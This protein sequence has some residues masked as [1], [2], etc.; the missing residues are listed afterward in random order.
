MSDFG[1]YHDDFI[2]STSLL[3]P[4]ITAFALCGLVASFFTAWLL[5]KIFPIMS[6]GILWFLIG[7]SLES[8]IFPLE[9]MHEHRNYLPSLGLFLLVAP[10]LVTKKRNHIASNFMSFGVVVAVF[11]YFI[12][13]THL[14]ADMYGDDFRRT[15]IEAGYRVESVRS[16]YEAGAVLANLYNQHREPMLM[17]LAK[18]HF[19]RVVAL[20][21][22]DKLALIGLMQLDCLSTQLVQTEIYNELKRRLSKGKWTYIDRT[23]MHG[24]A[25]MSNE[26]KLCLTR[27]Q[28]D[29]LFVI[30]L[31]SKTLTAQDRSVVFSD[32][33]LYLW[34]GQKDYFAARNILIRAVENGSDDVL[35]RMNLLQLFRFLG[36]KRNAEILLEDLNGRDLGRQDR[37]MVKKV[38]LEMSSENV[39]GGE[40]VKN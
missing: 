2:V 8:T 11:V 18:N 34:L 31:E 4:Y 40:N 27:N 36:D 28:V 29:E 20:D 23:V 3:V 10:G 9:L 13:I 38:A 15:Q 21:P 1:L 6:F 7:H 12:L 33:S 22:A 39:V 19:E 14:R 37:N 26:G 25:E 16:Q 32:Y 24:I 35:N 5:R 30:A 17:G